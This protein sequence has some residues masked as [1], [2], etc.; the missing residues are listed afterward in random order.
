MAD[1]TLWN[2]IIDNALSSDVLRVDRAD[3]IK[4]QMSPYMPG[5]DR[6]AAEVISPRQLMD[7]RDFDRLVKKSVDYH[8]RL[9]CLA[10]AG[11]GLGGGWF[12]LG[13][14]PADILQFYSHAIVL[15]QKMLYLYGWPQLT[16]RSGCMD[17]ESRRIV[18]LFLG[19]MMGAGIVSA[20]AGEVAE[21]AVKQAA[22][23]LP[24]NAAVQAAVNSA[25]EY[26]I[27]TT[28]VKLSKD[29]VGRGVAKVV[30]FI[31]APISAAITY[32]TF[33][34]MA[35]RLRKTLESEAFPV[36]EKVLALKK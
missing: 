5:L 18:T 11:A 32:R 14:I 25:M 12:L 19:E 7:R 30:P 29:A 34:V 15:L 4:A 3:F 35:S 10:S 22:I 6:E 16:G 26:V 33:R 2:K 17:D 21:A 23:R 1:R 27:K 13:T 20:L 24:Q 9:A 36:V 28:G 8:M 31:G